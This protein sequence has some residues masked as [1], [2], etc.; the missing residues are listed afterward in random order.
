MNKT[1]FSI[2]F[3]ILIISCASST[4]K[5]FQRTVGNN[6]SIYEIRQNLTFDQAWQKI[7]SIL[8]E[9][10][11]LN[12]INKEVGYIKTDWKYPKFHDEH[13]NYRV[14]VIA[15]FSTDKKQLKVKL[16]AETLIGANWV[17][18]MDS[19]FMTSIKTDILGSFA[20]TTR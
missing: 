11:D 19:A 16:L 3:L 13:K 15:K 2:I 1:V 18:C 20:R 4:P 9:N 17:A 8:V 10:Y 7:V 14:R 5:T 6:W 12:F